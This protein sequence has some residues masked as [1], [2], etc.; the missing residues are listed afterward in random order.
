[1]A[2]FINGKKKIIQNLQ[3]TITQAKEDNINLNLKLKAI[4]ITLFQPYLK[5]ILTFS[6]GLIDGNA[7]IKGSTAKPIITGKLN[8]VDITNMR[9]DYLNTFTE[10][11]ALLVY[12]RT[13]FNL[14]AIQQV[15]QT[16]KIQFGYT[17]QKTT[18]LQCGEIF[19]MIILKYLSWIL[20]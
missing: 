5:G 1:M 14:E 17:T 16:L 12:F 15:T 13:E 20:T 8:L 4:D 7:S 18:K 6:K 10:L 11:P 3:V 2:G 9:I 19:F